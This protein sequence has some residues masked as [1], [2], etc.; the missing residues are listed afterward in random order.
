G[1]IYQ[2]YDVTEDVY[3]DLLNASSIGSYFSNNIRNAYPTQKI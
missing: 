3:T 2:Y 1:A